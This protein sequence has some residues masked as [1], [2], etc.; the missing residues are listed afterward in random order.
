[1]RRFIPCSLNITKYYQ[2][3]QFKEDDMGGNVKLLEELRNTEKNMAG[4]SEENR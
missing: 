2:G 3:S 1:M 4:N